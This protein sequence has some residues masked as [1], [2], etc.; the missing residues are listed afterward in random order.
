M[1]IPD[2]GLPDP[3]DIVLID[4]TPVRG[5][6]QDGTR[7]GLIISARGMHEFSRRAIICPITRNRQPWPTKVFL[8]A[9]LAVEGAVLVDQVRS[10]DRRERILRRLDRV[11][12]AVLS[13]V[14]RKLAA[15]A[16]IGFPVR[17]RDAEHS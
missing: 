16:G 14:R 17:D 6:G 11:P 3:G 4:F 10:I 2:E 13:A 12:E 7:P 5:T 9:G 1:T 8:P 15:L